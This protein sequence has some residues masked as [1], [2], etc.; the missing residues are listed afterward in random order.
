MIRTCDFCWRLC[1]IKEGRRGFCGVR[2][3]RNGSIRTVTYGKVLAAAADPIEKKPFYHVMP[4]KKTLSAAL[5]GCNFTCSFCQNHDLS[6][7]DSP[8]FPAP[9]KDQGP[10]D[11]SPQ[12]LVSKMIECGLS[13]MSYTYS[14]PVV[15]QDYMLH[16]AE[17]VKQADGINCM[18]TNGSFSPAASQRIIPVIDAFNID[19]KGDEAFYSRWCSGSLKPV[20]ETVEKICSAPGK[21]LEVT[22]LLIEGIHDID[23]VYL[24][25]RQLK[26]AG[27]Q[28]WHLSRFFP[29]YRMEDHGPTSERFLRD[30]LQAAQSC[31]ISYV[32][33][34]NSGNQEYAKTRC[35]S[36]GNEIIGRRGY[37]VHVEQEL[38]EHLLL[39]LCI[40]CGEKIYGLFK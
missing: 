27:V 14:D 15:W 12:Q 21:I 26:D 35:P 25:G 16:T 30:A 5:F 38:M 2:E 11:T 34:G 24:L 29:H 20:M 33:A 10:D 17:L 36:C 32:Y 28:V 4:G 39:G 13:I 7:K 1:E 3:N 9:W 8:L 31:G 6:Q 37:Y 19:V 22:T 40:H 23:D 18:V